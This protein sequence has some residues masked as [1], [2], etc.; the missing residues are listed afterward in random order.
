M[1]E[2]IVEICDNDISYWEINKEILLKMRGCVEETKLGMRFCPQ[3]AA[4]MAMTGIRARV[5]SND[6]ACLS[7]I[8]DERCYLPE[9]L[10]EIQEEIEEL[11]KTIDSACGGIIE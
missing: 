4:R 11:L 9:D 2:M 8:T 5:H 3:K 1:D 7:L 10:K 6:E